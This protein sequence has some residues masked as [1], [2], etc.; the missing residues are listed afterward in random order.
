M[1]LGGR[2]CWLRPRCN[3]WNLNETWLWE[4]RMRDCGPVF[5]F[6]L[7]YRW[8]TGWAVTSVT[9]GSNSSGVWI[10]AQVCLLHHL[11]NCP[12]HPRLISSLS[13]LVHGWVPWVGV[14]PRTLLYCP[15]PVPDQL[16]GQSVYWLTKGPHSLHPERL[17]L[18]I[19][20]YWAGRDLG[21][22]G[23]YG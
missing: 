17:G 22:Y 9:P 8:K 10:W 3:V 20:N 13:V 23:I 14:E 1:L 7:L 21:H 4:V 2:G 6:Y 19:P 12:R 15:I 11:S 5:L 16:T 18:E